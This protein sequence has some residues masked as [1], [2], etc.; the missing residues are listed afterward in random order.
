M[1]ALLLAAAEPAPLKTFSDWAV[2]CDN[3]RLCQ[4]VG[5]V[6]EDDVEAATMMVL[7]RPEAGAEPRVAFSMA[8][9]TAP[10]VEVDGRRFKALDVASDDGDTAV[11]PQARAFLDALLAG[12]KAALIGPD[13]KSV[14]ALS[15]AGAS[16]ALLYIDDKQGRVGT[17]T[18]LARRGDKP[19]AAVPP[20]PP[21][22][23]VQAP[24]ASSK[25]GRMASAPAIA[26][27]RDDMTC[28]TPAEEEAAQAHRLDERHSLVLVPVKCGSGAYNFLSVAL[29]VDEAGKAR[30]GEF[31]REKGGE[32]NWLM[33]AEWVPEER[34]LSTYG[35][36]RGIGDCGV[37]QAYA[38]DGARFRLVEQ[39]QMDECRGSLDWITTWRAEVRSR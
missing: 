24:P 4:A 11:P 13:G 15:T 18:A 2:G 39:H 21:L 31:E 30:P 16:A 22:P 27:A 1:L 37:S 28:E 35:K 29:V 34:R 6:P 20:P 10:W 12:K 9:E 33:N 14:G 36:G 25:P 3:G 32:T 19:A 5:L 7:R 38:W 17:V 26:A 8:A 23:M